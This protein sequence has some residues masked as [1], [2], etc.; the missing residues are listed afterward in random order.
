MTKISE[1]PNTPT[2]PIR[3]LAELRA[4]EG[5]HFLISNSLDTDIVW[6]KTRE[7]NQFWREAFHGQRPPILAASIDDLR[8][9]GML[10]EPEK[11]IQSFERVDKPSITLED[12]ARME[13][14]HEAITS[15]AHYKVAEGLE[16]VDIIR[17]VLTP[18]QFKGYCIG[19]LIKYRMRAGKKAM[20]PMEDLGKAHV[21]ETWLK[22][23]EG[24]EG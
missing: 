5:P 11:I 17:A 18:E 15:P 8:R 7:G 1:L 2:Y 19:N 14:E 4:K 23:M 22:E 12:Y 13:A 9:A 6:A 10:P 3:A 24:G 20:S 16:V 21:Y